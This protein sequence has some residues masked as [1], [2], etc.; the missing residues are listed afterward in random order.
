MRGLLSSFVL[1]LIESMARIG[2]FP[3]KRAG[4]RRRPNR[5][6]SDLDSF[7]VLVRL[8]LFDHSYST[9][10]S[11]RLFFLRFSVESSF[12]SKT[13]PLRLSGC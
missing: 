2:M 1:K 10:T 9:R 13:I 11:A 5:N 3:E 12:G 4:Q 8:D 6:T 7:H